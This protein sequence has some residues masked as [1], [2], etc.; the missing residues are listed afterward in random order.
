MKKIDNSKPSLVE[1]LGSIK[2]SRDQGHSSL[3]GEC[4][5]HFARMRPMTHRQQPSEDT[6]LIRSAN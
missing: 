5:G 6:Q 1:F 3:A 2:F 4:S